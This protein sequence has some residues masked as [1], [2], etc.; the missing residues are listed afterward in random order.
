MYLTIKSNLKL[1]KA[2]ILYLNKLT[3]TAKNLYNCALYQVRQYYIQ[4]GEYLSYEKNYQLLKTNANYQ[5]LQSTQAQGIIRKVDEAMK[6]FFNHIKKGIKGV[7]LPRYLKKDSYFPL[8]DRMVYKPHRKYYVLPMSKRIHKVIYNRI[9]DKL[10]DDIKRLEIKR[11]RVKTPVLIQDRQIKEITIK[12]SR[13][14]KQFSISYVYKD[15]KKYEQVT[16]HTP[17]EMGIDF[18]YH[19]LAFCATK[20]NHLLLDGRYVMSL[21]QWYHKHM[22]KLSS[23]RLDQNVLTHQMKRLINKRNNQMAYYINKSAR[24]IIDFSIENQVNHIMMGYNDGFKD[25]NLSKRYN[26]MTKSIPIAR[27]RDRITLLAKRHGIRLVIVNEAYTSKASFIDNE[28]LRAY[29]FSGIRIKRGLFQTKDGKLMNADLNAALN[30]IR[31]SK[32]EFKVGYSGLN[33]PKRTY[34]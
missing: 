22:A 18:G 12:P 32:A 34:L 33:T 20:K 6:S 13:D 9:D 11:M 16:T 7:R 10:I 17:N 15:E 23:K 3:R 25:I 4:H 31:K 24:L 27:L 5:L 30:I 21:N 8:I 14:G 26:Q 28:P 19:N 2:E 1:G 29:P